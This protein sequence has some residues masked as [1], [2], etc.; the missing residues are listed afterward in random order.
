[1]QLAPGDPAIMRMGRAAAKP[2]NQAALEK[3]RQEMGLDKPI[4]VQYVVWLGGVV[5]G[6]FGNS[7][8]SN[9]PVVELIAGRLPRAMAPLGLDTGRMPASAGRCGSA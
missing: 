2:E 3:L 4:L 5:Q 6:D 9:R 1:M 8:R 7:N